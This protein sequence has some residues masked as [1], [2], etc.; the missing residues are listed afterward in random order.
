MGY[1]NNSGSIQDGDHVK[2]RA[3]GR[4]YFTPNCANRGYPNDGI[5]ARVS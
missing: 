2:R 5:P 4:L 3:L 1:L